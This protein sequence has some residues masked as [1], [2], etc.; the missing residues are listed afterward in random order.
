[1]RADAAG[2]WTAKCAGRV[3]PR[4]RRFPQGVRNDSQLRFIDDNPF[5]LR[6]FDLT[7]LPPPIA[8]GVPTPHDLAAIRLS[9]QDSPD[10]SWVPSRVAPF[11]L[12]APCSL[13]V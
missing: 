1:M 6:S 2:P 5:A 9:V 7:F 12:G 10:D 8:T 13:C 11:G 3:N 4:V